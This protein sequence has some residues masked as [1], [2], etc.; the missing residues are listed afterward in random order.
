MPIAE[1]L[2]IPLQ[3]LKARYQASPIPGFLAW[4]TGE[5]V[6]MLPPRW[7]SALRTQ[8]PWVEI[9]MVPGGLDL[10]LGGG[11]EPRRLELRAEDAEALS[12]ALEQGLGENAARL[13]RV[14]LLPPAKVLRRQISL[15]AAARE[16]LQAVLGFELDRQTPFKPDQVHFDSR[17][18]GEEAGGKQI[19]V[20]LALIPRA[21]LDATLTALGP[22]AGRLDAVDARAPS[23]HR[24]GFNLLPPDRRI[25]RANLWLWVNAGLVAATLMFLVLA[26]NQTLANREEAIVQLDAQVEDQRSQA[27]AVTQ[28]RRSLDE[29]VEGGNFLA[30]KRAGQPLMIDLLDEL[31]RLLP[32]DTYLERLNFDGEQVTIHGLSSQAAALLPLL[33]ASEQ[34]HDPSLSG[35]IQ[36]DPRV[37][38]DRFQITAGF[39]PQTKEAP[40]AAQARR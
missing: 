36:P 35:P 7:Q 8:R 20:E 15:P 4:W 17:V 18:L 14:L 10:Q 11:S 40:R 12:Q 29:A 21:Q 19:R 16:R 13:R 39:G 2:D 32:D 30:N 28:L 33:Q 34:L 26:M 6:G 9:E 38:K 27:R 5:L 25:K 1:A 31:T 22:L 37:G 24:A 3:R 23:G